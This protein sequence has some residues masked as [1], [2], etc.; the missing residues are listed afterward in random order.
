MRFFRF[1][2]GRMAKNGAFAFLFGTTEKKREQTSRI[3]S[4]TVMVCH[5]IFWNFYAVFEKT[6][7]LFQNPPFL[8]G[9]SVL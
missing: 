1:F 9:K 7:S 4:S 3:L 6:L 2:G 8:F 5:T